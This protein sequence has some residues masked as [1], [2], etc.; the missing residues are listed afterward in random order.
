[1]K[2]IL[3]LVALTVTAICFTMSASA[4]QDSARRGGGRGGRSPEERAKM[5][6]EQMTKTL[7]LTT[8]QV[9]KVEVINLKYAKAQTGGWGGQGGG[10]MEARMAAMKKT[11][12]EKNAEFKAVLTEKQYADYLKMQE[13]NLQ[14]MK[15]RMKNGPGGGGN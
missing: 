14:R 6:T 12:D 3:L 11:Q 7:S 8:E 10:D 5:Q 13:E 1:M 15:D 2:R 4:Q 9:A